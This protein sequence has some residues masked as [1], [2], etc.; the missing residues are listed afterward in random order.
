L[1][2]AGSM[3]IS[4]WGNTTPTFMANLLHLWIDI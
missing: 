1:I 2:T 4:V 3:P